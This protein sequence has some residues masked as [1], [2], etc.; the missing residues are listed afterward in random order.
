M[1]SKPSFVIA[2]VLISAVA[3]V[4][5]VRALAGWSVVVTGFS[6]PV[7]VSYVVAGLLGL[8]AIFLWRDLR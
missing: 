5:L 4:Q 7:W 8:L 2:A 1:T 3:V 6:V